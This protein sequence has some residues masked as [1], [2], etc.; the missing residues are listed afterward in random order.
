MRPRKESYNNLMLVKLKLKPRSIPWSVSPYLV[1][2]I[3]Y[4]FILRQH[5]TR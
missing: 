1:S 2:P 4:P 5:L 3:P